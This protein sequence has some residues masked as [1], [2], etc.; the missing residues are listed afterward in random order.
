MDILIRDGE[1]KHEAKAPLLFY[2]KL[3]LW[4]EFGLKEKRKYFYGTI[5]DSISK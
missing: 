2:R 4:T 5:K 3:K 1:K